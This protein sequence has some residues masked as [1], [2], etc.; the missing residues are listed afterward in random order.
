MANTGLITS[1]DFASSLVPKFVAMAPITNPRSR[2]N[3]VDYPM[4]NGN[5]SSEGNSS[6]V[7]P[8]GMILVV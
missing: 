6:Q 5:I 4:A 7:F 2:E 3:R 1:V 8:N